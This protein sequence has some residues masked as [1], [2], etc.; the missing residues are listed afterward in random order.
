MVSHSLYHHFNLKS[1]IR[2]L[3]W[4]CFSLCPSQLVGPGHPSKT[5]CPDSSPEHLVATL[6]AA[7]LVLR[8][9]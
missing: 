3:P 6:Q 1:L 8:R 9:D 2:C 4:A 7:G 5:S